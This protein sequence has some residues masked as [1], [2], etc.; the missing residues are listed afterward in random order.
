MMSVL[1]N[2]IFS[3]TQD[4]NIEQKTIISYCAIKKTWKLI[5]RMAYQ[6]EVAIF[7]EAET[8]LSYYGSHAHIDLA[9]VKVSKKS[10]GKK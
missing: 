7:I 1:K 8:V 2:C 10:S 5:S 3:H 9:E 4:Y 6:I